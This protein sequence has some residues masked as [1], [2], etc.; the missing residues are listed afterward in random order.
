MATEMRIEIAA[1]YKKILTSTGPVTVDL[2]PRMPKTLAAKLA[3]DRQHFVVNPS[4]RGDEMRGGGLERR[5][6]VVL[7]IRPHGRDLCARVIDPL[8]EALL[9]GTRLAQ[10]GEL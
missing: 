4:I 2:T 8:I 5:G 1:N 7:R 10:G 9:L 3:D 6:R